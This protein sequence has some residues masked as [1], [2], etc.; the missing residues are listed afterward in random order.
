[1][2]NSVKTFKTYYIFNYVDMS[3]CKIKLFQLHNTFFE[4]Y[5]NLKFEQTFVIW[6]PS[7]QYFFVS[8]F[9]KLTQ[10]GG[11]RSERFDFWVTSCKDCDFPGDSFPS[12]VITFRFNPLVFLLKQTDPR[13]SRSEWQKQKV[14]H[15]CIVSSHLVHQNDTRNK[16][17]ERSHSHNPQKLNFRV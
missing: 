5:S 11:R 3:V 17:L 8:V 9:M 16:V 2:K 15:S 14:Q 13:E 6:V 4:T 10:D 7:V 12:T 1:M